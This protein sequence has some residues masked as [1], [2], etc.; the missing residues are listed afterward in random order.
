MIWVFLGG[1]L[2]AMCRYELILMGRNDSYPL[3][4]LIANIVG[5]FLLGLFWE[6]KPRLSS[7]VWL[8]LT[9]GFCGGLTTFSTF[10]LELKQMSHQ[11][12]KGIVYLLISLFLGLLALWIGAIVSSSVKRW[13]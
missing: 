10:I 1:G 6:L 4:T 9:T 11:P 8:L 3:P 12:T 13:I 2:G 7:P 5:C